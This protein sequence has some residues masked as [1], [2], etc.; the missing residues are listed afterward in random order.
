MAL[1]T[2]QKSILE[3][4]KLVSKKKALEKPIQTMKHDVQRNVRTAIKSASKP[5]IGSKIKG[6]LAIG[7]I[8][9]AGLT[10]SK[11]ATPKKKKLNEGDVI[12]IPTS[13][14]EKQ[15]TRLLLSLKQQLDSAQK[16]QAKTKVE[17]V[18]REAKLS[19]A[20]ERLKVL[21][22][23]ANKMPGTPTTPRPRIPFGK[24]VALMAAISV[25][26]RVAY[27]TMQKRAQT[28]NKRILKD[29]ASRKAKQKIKESIMENEFLQQLN[30][31][32]RAQA[33][34][35]QGPNIPYGDDSNRPNLIRKCTM[36]EIATQKINCL[37]KLRD[38]AAMNP[39][40]QHRID[41]YIDEITDTYEPTSKPGTIPGNEF[42]TSG[43]GED[44]KVETVTEGIK[45]KA[46]DIFMKKPE[47]RNPPSIAADCVKL[48]AVSKKIFKI[49]KKIK[50]CG[51]DKACRR[52]W[53][54]TYQPLAKRQEALYQK[55]SGGCR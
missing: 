18:A 33:Q 42:K 12:K 40:Y 52:K 41:R 35:W 24:I 3:K 50:E 37:R 53:I 27:I 6:A 16:M 8:T 48:E 4:L 51:N 5:G 32:N 21:K 13:V 55:T 38:Q 23:L 34:E 54:M 20:R 44:T 26:L 22:R 49:R 19:A 43:V 17:I 36:M 46:K 15:A 31:D 14:T 1:N 25:A 2:L 28:S 7:G 39:F 30:T 11:H 10:Y 45:E 9:A 47:P 29:R